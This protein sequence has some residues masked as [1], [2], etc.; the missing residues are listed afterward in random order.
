M[1]LYFF[2]VGLQLSAKAP[3]IIPNMAPTKKPPMPKRLKR[4]IVYLLLNII[5][6]E[7]IIETALSR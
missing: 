7:E 1:T 2:I 6:S 3:P 4:G 5:M